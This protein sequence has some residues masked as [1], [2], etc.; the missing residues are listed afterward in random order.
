MQGPQ[1]PYPKPGQ[2]ERTRFLAVY[3]AKRGLSTKEIVQIPLHA[4]RWVHTTVKRYNEEGPEPLKDRRHQNPGQRPKLTPG[5]PL[6]GSP[7]SQVAIFVGS[8]SA[9]HSGPMPM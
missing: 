5:Q 2:V 6:Q 3:Y 7:L 9:A 4:P 1:A 8:L